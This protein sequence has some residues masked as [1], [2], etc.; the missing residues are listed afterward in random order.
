MEDKE[1]YERLTK[2]LECPVCLVIP[3][4]SIFICSKGHSICDLCRIQLKKCP[5][6]T[7]DFLEDVARNFVAQDLVSTLEQLK[8]CIEEEEKKDI[9]SQTD[10]SVQTKYIVH[11][12]HTQTDN[13]KINK[14]SSVH[15]QTNITMKKSCNLQNNAKK[16]HPCCMIGSCKYNASHEKLV[17]HLRHFHRQHFLEES[18]FSK[19]FP[20][21]FLVHTNEFPTQ[22]D[23]AFSVNNMVIIFLKFIIRKGSLKCCVV[24]INKGASL[25]LLGYEAKIISEAYYENYYGKV[26]PYTILQHDTAN[27]YDVCFHANQMSNIVKTESFHL[28]FTVGTV[29]SNA[30]E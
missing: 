22:I 25:P 4:S 23:F 19:I 13:I 2:V 15:T 17:L 11:S 30:V 20:K 5:I 28:I 9:K 7:S 6:C 21:T 24:F 12:V 29:K 3:E 1:W 8:L 10:Q 16:P 18:Q 26:K 14:L 27:I